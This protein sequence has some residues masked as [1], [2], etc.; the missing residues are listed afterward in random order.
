MVT[1]KDFERL[2]KMERVISLINSSLVNLGFRLNGPEEDFDLVVCCE[3]PILTID[4]GNMIMDELNKM[5]YIYGMVESN[6]FVGG[7]GNGFELKK[8]IIVTLF[9]KMITL[10]KND[11]NYTYNSNKPILFEDIESFSMTIHRALFDNYI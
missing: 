2:R 10:L 11:H 1:E 7:V 6:S 3:D 9:M 4:H 8:N 5:Y